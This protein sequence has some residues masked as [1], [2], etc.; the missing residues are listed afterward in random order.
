MA[1]DPF[2]AEPPRIGHHVELPRTKERTSGFAIESDW[3]DFGS[4]QRIMG[5]A[6][7]FAPTRKAPMFHCAIL[8]DRSSPV[9]YST[10]EAPRNQAAKGLS[11]QVLRLHARL[12]RCW[13]EFN[14][15][16]VLGTPQWLR[17]WFLYTVLPQNDQFPWVK[18]LTN[19][20]PHFFCFTANPV[21]IFKDFAM[22]HFSVH[23]LFLNFQ[24]GIFCGLKKS[25]PL[26]FTVS[27][28]ITQNFD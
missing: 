14:H 17:I 16:N 27:R 6:L 10:V 1:P 20:I 13:V 28:N 19:F 7:T 23:V 25:S 26:R 21:Q 24:G 2:Q 15:G 12:A 8:L 11:P 3:G 9:F 4:A 18:I 22:A 5:K